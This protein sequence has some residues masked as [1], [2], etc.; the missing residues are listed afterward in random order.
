MVCI[1]VYVEWK[2]YKH[3]D[4][5]KTIRQLKFKWTHENLFFFFG[6][7]WT[8][9]NLVKLVEHSM[10]ERE[11]LYG[12]CCWFKHSNSFLKWS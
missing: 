4:Y 9:E 8:Q 2:N 7:G 6:G 1:C 12:D 11:F 3:I 10:Y 5:M